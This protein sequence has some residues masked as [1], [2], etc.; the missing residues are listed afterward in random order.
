[1][2]YLQQTLSVPFKLNDSVDQVQFKIWSKYE[3]MLFMGHAGSSLHN[4]R[5]SRT[6]LG[7]LFTILYTIHFH[8][9]SRWHSLRLFDTRYK[10]T[11]LCYN[12]KVMRNDLALSYYIP[13]SKD[14]KLDAPIMIHASFALNGG[15]FLI[16]FSVL[17]MIIGAIM[18]SFCT[19]GAS[20][21]FVPLLAPLLFIL[22]LFCL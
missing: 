18:M 4:L 16:S 19:C 11:I 17:L 21:I 22:P 13:E 20:L 5:Y 15:C 1:M 9:R 12:G 7:A 6:F 8:V 2:L 14:E 10:H 3:N